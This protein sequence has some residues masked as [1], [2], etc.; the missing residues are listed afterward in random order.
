MDQLI[1]NAS[2]KKALSRLATTGH[3]GQSLLLAGPSGV[4]KSLFAS[5][6][7]KLVC[8]P[9][10]HH[11]LD[12]GNHPDFHLYTPEG[13][14]GLHSIE[15]LRALGKEVGLEPNEAPYKIF[16]I[17]EADR[18]PPASA[19]ALLKT[20][21]EPPPRTLLLLTTSSRDTLLPTILSRCRTL[22][23]SPVPTKEIVKHLNIPEHIAYA[24]R[25]SIAR[26]IRLSSRKGETAREAVLATLTQNGFR[27]HH[28]LTTECAQIAA[29]LEAERDLLSAVEFSHE[30]DALFSDI[31]HWYRDLHLLKEAG[32]IRHISH[33][34]HIPQLE[35]HTAPLPPQE[36]VDSALRHARLSIDRF[37]KLT[38]CL[39]D[40]FLCL[41]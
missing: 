6:F 26:A 36:T 20:L 41:S 14:S 25:G 16:L 9:D 22:Y 28:E 39:E 21:E 1:G 34:H 2:A 8:G 31:A 29:A 27:D 10:H 11:K 17:E 5:A 24:S 3:I 19:N 40:L 13:K 7:A 18:M 30:L 23:F 12:T 4:G 32:D 37:T 15:S 35:A 33:R 38:T